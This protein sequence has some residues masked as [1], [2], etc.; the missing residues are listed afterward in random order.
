MITR[1]AITASVE[2]I[3]ELREHEIFFLLVFAANGGSTLGRTASRIIREL[4][5]KAPRCLRVRFEFV[6]RFFELFAVNP[7][8]NSRIIRVARKLFI[9]SSVNAALQSKALNAYTYIRF[10][11]VNRFFEQTLFVAANEAV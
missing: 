5:S 7:L 6:S 3:V 2:L 11:F 4:K 9:N 1:T 8:C 10:E